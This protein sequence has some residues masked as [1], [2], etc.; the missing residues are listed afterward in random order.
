MP[1]LYDVFTWAAVGVAV[2]LV[3]ALAAFP[4]AVRVGRMLRNRD[5]WG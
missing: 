4:I 5:N 1:L 2:L 3:W